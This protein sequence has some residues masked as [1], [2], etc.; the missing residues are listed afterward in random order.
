MADPLLSTSIQVI[1]WADRAE[2][3]S[4]PI[5]RLRQA[6]K[7][8]ACML[9]DGRG[10]WEHGTDGGPCYRC[11]ETGIDPGGEGAEELRVKLAQVHK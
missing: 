4:A 9:C 6:I 3:N 11:K 7:N 8:V 10:Y 2:I 5:I 1:E